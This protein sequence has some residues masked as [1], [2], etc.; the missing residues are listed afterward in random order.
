[1]TRNE[2]IAR[3]DNAKRLLESE[4]FQRTLDELVAQTFGEFG[5]TAPDEDFIRENLH[6]DLRSIQRL[7]DRLQHFV[8]DA[9]QEVR[10]AEFDKSL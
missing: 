8:D 4:M 6:G 7:R 9:G 10:N 3:G 1:M 2:K 5:A